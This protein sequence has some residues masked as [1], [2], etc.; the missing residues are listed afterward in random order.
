M[1]RPRKQ[2]QLAKPEHLSYTAR[3]I[4]DEDKEEFRRAMR[5]VKPLNKSPNKTAAAKKKPFKIQP[6]KAEKES[7]SKATHYF[8]HPAED[9]YGQTPWAG[10]ED[11]LAFSKSGLQ[12]KTI[13]QLQ[14]GQISIEQ[15]LDL[16]GLNAEEALDL[17]QTTLENCQ[18]LNRRLL[19]VIHGKGHY[20][21]GDTPVLK[22]VLNQWLRQSPMVLAFHSALPKHGGAGAIYILL[23]N[24][25]QK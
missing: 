9:I 13:Q 19:L 7:S 20:S 4:N 6:K 16:H 21:S 17:L 3:M 12:Q 2:S 15:R 24:K 14:R 23:K 11:E 10:P 25:R 8:V 5:Q 22:N 18:Q 1:R